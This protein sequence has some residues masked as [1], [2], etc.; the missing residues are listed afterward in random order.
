MTGLLIKDLLTLKKTFALYLLIVAF[1]AILGL[2][3]GDAGMMGGYLAVLAAILP[4]S[5]LSY[6]ER[7]RWPR[8]AAALPV[9][10]RLMVAEKYVLALGL[11]LLGLGLCL[12]FVLT[13]G[14]A[15]RAENLGLCLLFFLMGQ[16][17][18]AVI[19]PL[20]FRFGT[21]RGRVLMVAVMAVPVVL[22]LALGQALDPALEALVAWGPGLGLPAVLG[23]LLLSCLLSQRIFARQNL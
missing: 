5:S 10:R 19:L 12:L 6:D 3:T 20:M 2:K 9:S 14:Q 16:L 15:G 11:G 22:I 18:N 7:C 8:Y 1:Y 17:F 4:V 23:L 21:E 13:G